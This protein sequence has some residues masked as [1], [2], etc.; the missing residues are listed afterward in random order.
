MEFLTAACVRWTLNI[1][2]SVLHSRP[3]FSLSLYK[4]SRQS[5]AVHTR[6]CKETISLYPRL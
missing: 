5:Q 3:T 4:K 2:I 6:V 1:W